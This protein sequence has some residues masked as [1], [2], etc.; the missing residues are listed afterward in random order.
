MRWAAEVFAEQAAQ[1]LVEEPAGV[2]PEDQQDMQE[3]LG[4]GGR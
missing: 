2:Q 1:V 3:R 4:P